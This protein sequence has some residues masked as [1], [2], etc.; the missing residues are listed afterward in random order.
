MKLNKPLTGWIFYDFANSAFATTVLAVIFNLYFAKVIAGGTEGIQFRHPFGVTQIAG[1]ALW[2]FLVAFSTAI[3]AI[4][5]P[6]LGAMADYSSKKKR[7]LAFY[8][9]MGVIGTIALAWAGEGDLLYAALFFVIANLGFAGGNVF[10]NSFLPSIG[11]KETYGRISGY[12]CGVGYIGG[13]LC[14]IINLIMLQKPELLGFE[15]GSFSVGDCM[16]VA[17]VWWGLFALPT[18]LWLKEPEISTTKL[19]LWKLSKMGIHRLKNTYSEI[20]S[21]KQLVRFLISYLIFND[22]IETVII[23]AT[24]FG[25]EVVGLSSPEL[26]AYFIIIQG[27]GFVGSMFFGRLSDRIGNKHSLLICLS[28]WL[29]IV[30]WAFKLGWLVSLKTDYYIIGILAGFVLG[31]SQASARSLQALFT[32]PEKS[33]EFFG[34]FSVSGRFAS[35]FGPLV[36]GITIVITGSLQTGILMLSIIFVVGGAILWTVDEKSYQSNS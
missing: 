26:I 30:L 31:G 20:K 18:M 5:S 14:L 3:V 11:T 35:I 24:I 22:G 36:Y 7:L 16:I 10:Y 17:G 12:A 19:S 9:Y 34:F 32:P 28:V 13:G 15:A 33:A 1:S 6:L 27:M 29:I 8:C 23:M 25:S 21:H 2:S 4:S